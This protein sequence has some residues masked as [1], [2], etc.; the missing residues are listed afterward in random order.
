MKELNIKKNEI[1]YINQLIEK[2]D[3][4]KYRNV[5]LDLNVSEYKTI[6]DDLFNL[7]DQEALIHYIEFGI[8]EGRHNSFKSF[9]SRLEKKEIKN[10]FQNNIKSKGK[11]RLLKS[12]SEKLDLNV[13]EYKTI[14]DDLFLLEDIKAIQHYM[15]VGIE[16]KRYKSFD[17]IKN[18]LKPDID[19]KLYSKILD[20]TYKFRRKNLSEKNFE[21]IYYHLVDEKTQDFAEKNWKNFKFNSLADLIFCLI[22][23]NQISP[24]PIKNLLDAL[25]DNVFIEATNTNGEILINKKL[26]SIL[27]KGSNFEK[28]QDQTNSIYL[29]ILL[30]RV[31]SVEDQFIEYLS[32]DF[33]FSCQYYLCLTSFVK[34]LRSLKVSKYL[35]YLFFQY[36][37][38][39]EIYL[40]KNFSDQSKIV[41]DNDKYLKNVRKIAIYSSLSLKG[42]N[43]L[44]IEHPTLSFDDLIGGLKTLLIYSC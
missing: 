25:Y 15:V 14:Y 9:L 18:K 43:I 31:L 36:M 39:I 2:F 35:E 12:V 38:L 13:S 33:E 6:Y 29:L 7:T 11:Q 28:L 42:K 40:I 16:E 19:L 22:T 3:A 41:L 4:D 21:N 20:S 1:N 26:I 24:I 44:F 23:D 32:N 30:T 10:C 8:K 17:Q 5:I 27:V 34:D 37:V